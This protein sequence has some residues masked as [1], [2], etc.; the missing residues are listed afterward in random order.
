MKID[1]LVMTWLYPRLRE[2]PPDAW[3]A[4]LD[5]ASKTELDT[6]ELIGVISGVALTAWLLGTVPVTL[7]TQAALVGHLLNFVLALPL[8][9]AV[10]GPLYLRR[11]RRGLERELRRNYGFNADAELPSE[12]KEA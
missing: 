6:L 7:T 8:L 2:V 5:K 1:R 3:K 4:T 12:R 11:T 10:T 9:A